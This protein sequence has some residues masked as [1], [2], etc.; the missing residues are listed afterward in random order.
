MLDLGSRTTAGVPA[1]EDGG[2][3]RR[4]EPARHRCVREY[5]HGETLQIDLPAGTGLP[6]AAQSLRHGPWTCL[7]VTLVRPFVEGLMKRH[8][9]C[10]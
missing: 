4:A 1:A 2:G 6:A 9:R 10:A 7:P 3:Q 8:G 5:E